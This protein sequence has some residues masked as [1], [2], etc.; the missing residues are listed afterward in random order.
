MFTVLMI[1]ITINNYHS[2]DV[3]DNLNVQNGN[4][5]ITVKCSCLSTI[6]MPEVNV[7]VILIT[8]NNYHSSDVIDNLNVQNGNLHITV[9][10]SCLSTISMPEVNSVTPAK[11][12]F[13]F[14]PPKSIQG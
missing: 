12:Q 4:L 10:C 5:H 7:L 1:L 11:F 3:F 2:S 14:I 13:G 8:I 9:K 6:S